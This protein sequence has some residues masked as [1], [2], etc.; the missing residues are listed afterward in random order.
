MQIYCFDA[1]RFSSFE[2]AVK[3][4]GRLRA[5]ST[6]F[7]VITIHGFTAKSFPNHMKY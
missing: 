6:L 4:K 5:L 3:G 7:E 2:E 1:D